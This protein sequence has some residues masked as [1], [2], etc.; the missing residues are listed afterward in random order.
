MES[1][2]IGGLLAPLA[3]PLRRSELAL[4]LR[5]VGVDARILLTLDRPPEQLMQLHRFVLPVLR[6]W[7]RLSIHLA[8]PR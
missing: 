5:A 7:C 1:K 6:M 4:E 3:Q 2:L 8:E